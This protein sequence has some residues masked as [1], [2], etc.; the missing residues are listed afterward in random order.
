MAPSKIVVKRECEI[1]VELRMRG[2]VSMGLVLSF[3][4]ILILFRNILAFPKAL[5]IAL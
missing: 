5:K 3:L 2:Q 1:Y 4:L